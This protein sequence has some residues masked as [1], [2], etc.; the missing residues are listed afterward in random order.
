MCH[1]AA[2]EIAIYFEQ[3]TEHMRQTRTGGFFKVGRGLAYNIKSGF[4]YPRTSEY[5]F[6]ISLMEIPF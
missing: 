6:N 5:F 1:Y 2:T 4:Q 3:C